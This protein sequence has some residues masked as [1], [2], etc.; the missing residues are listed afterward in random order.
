MLIA[1]SALAKNVTV[2]GEG[3]SPSEAENK[4]LQNAV[5]NTLG[6]LVDSQTHDACKVSGDLI[7]FDAGLD[8]GVVRA[9]DIVKRGQ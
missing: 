4:A 5:E 3:I 7:Y 1:A 6:V 2:S 9:G 8:S